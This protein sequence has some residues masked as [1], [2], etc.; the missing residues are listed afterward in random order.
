MEK[1]L[2]DFN[3]YFRVVTKYIFSRLI[4]HFDL[5]FCSL[6]PKLLQILIPDPM[7]IF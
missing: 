2:T 3:T 7:K 5:K 4:P 6:I 1:T